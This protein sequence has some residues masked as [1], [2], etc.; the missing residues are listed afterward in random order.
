MESEIDDLLEG[1]HVE[2]RSGGQKRGRSR[3]EI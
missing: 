2:G 1:R 3:F